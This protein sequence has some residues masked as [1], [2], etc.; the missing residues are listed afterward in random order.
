MIKLSY[1]KRKDLKLNMKSE[2]K[3]YKNKA[4]RLWSEIKKNRFMY[5]LLLPSVVLV[6]LFTYIPFGGVRI[7][8]QEYN[9]YN[10]DASNWIGLENFKEI[11]SSKGMLKAIW[12]TLA[13]SLLS[14]VTTFPAGIIFALMINELKNGIFK[15]TVQTVSYLPHFLSWISVIGIASGFYAISG[16]LN[17]LSLMFG[18]DERVMFLAQQSF[19]VPN[20]IILSLWKEVGWGS[21]IYL[22]AISGV[23]PSL[24]E[25]ATIDGAGRFRQTLSVT[26]PSIMPTVV[27]MLILKIGSLLAS[28][29]ELIYGLQN[30]FVDYEVLSTVIY[31]QGIEGGEYAIATAFGLFQGVVSLILIITANF[32]SKKAADISIV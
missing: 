8:F 26:L 2:N 29:F 21:I 23:D 13:I 20:V 30:P 19:F 1:Q 3:L 22:A 11:L 6:I 4:S 10:P 12:N 15:K 28:N 17:D 25:A 18:A 16:S 32:F 27:I 31:K 24:Y 9:I 5:F 14:L 7:A